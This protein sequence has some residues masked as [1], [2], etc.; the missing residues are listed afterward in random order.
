ME[1]ARKQHGKAKREFDKSF[2][3]CEVQ[4]SLLEKERN[5]REG[6]ILKEIEAEFPK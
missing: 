1:D 3:K 2:E 6:C 5:A 4:R